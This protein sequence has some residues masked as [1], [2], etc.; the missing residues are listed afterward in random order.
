M[1]SLPRFFNRFRPQP[2]A[3]KAWRAID[4]QQTHA[5][6]LFAAPVHMLLGRDSYFMHDSAPLSLASTDAEQLIQDLNQHFNR[7]GLYF[8]LQETV[9]FLGL[10]TDPQITTTPLER[11]IG[12]DVA[13]YLPAGAG[14]LAWAKL[15]NEI[16][17]LLFAHPVNARREQ[18][19]LPVVNSLWCYGGAPL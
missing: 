5:Y 16:Q 13:P 19:K 7:D 15:Q 17:M 14:A 1:I 8:Y 2:N 12:L 4:G 11:V 18:Q 3:A 9:W 10:D 6:W